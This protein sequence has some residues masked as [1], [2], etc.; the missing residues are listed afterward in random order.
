MCSHCGWK[1]NSLT[2]KDRN[3]YCKNCGISHD[4]DINAALTLKRLATETALPVASYAVINDTGIEKL[5]I[6][7]GKV[8]FNTMIEQLPD[9][10]F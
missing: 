1:S 10:I 3:W 5:S 8:F 9:V 2:L 6:S 4:R 7:G